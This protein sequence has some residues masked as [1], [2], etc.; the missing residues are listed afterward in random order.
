MRTTTGR[1]DLPGYNAPQIIKVNAKGKEVER[2][3]G[4]PS[5]VWYRRVGCGG[6]EGGEVSRVGAEPRQHLT[7]TIPPRQILYTSTCTHPSYSNTLNRYLSPIQI[8]RGRGPTEVLWE[9]HPS[10][11][12]TSSLA[13]KMPLSRWRLSHPMSGFKSSVREEDLTESGYSFLSPR[14]QVY[15]TSGPPHSPTISIQRSGSGPSLDIAHFDGSRT[16]LHVDLRL[17][18]KTHTDVEFLLVVFETFM[19]VKDEAANAVFSRRDERGR[20]RFEK[21]GRVRGAWDR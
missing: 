1:P 13:R 11:T 15:L 14:Q 12:T 18:E 6:G 16:V 20:L 8:H 3:P 7:H 9:S 21:V 5:L 2:S 19:A 4:G 17:C 10:N